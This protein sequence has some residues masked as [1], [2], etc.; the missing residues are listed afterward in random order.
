MIAKMRKKRKNAATLRVADT[1]IPLTGITV[2][3]PSATKAEKPRE[4]SVRI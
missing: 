1:V 2:K 3:K 4:R